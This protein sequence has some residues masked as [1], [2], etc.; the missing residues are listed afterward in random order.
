MAI[1]K[2]LIHFKKKSDFIKNQSNLLETSIIFIKDTQE[3]WTHGQLYNCSDS[4]KVK[5]LTK[6][7]YA[8]L[9]EKDEK[10]VYFIS[11]ETLSDDWYEGT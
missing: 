9:V 10:T 6:A 4:D 7:E 1:N 2:K 11:D 3:I 5:I 8:A